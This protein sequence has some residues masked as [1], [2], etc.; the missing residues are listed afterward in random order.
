[1]KKYTHAWLALK[2]VEWLRN[3]AGRFNS[4]R[5]ERLERFLEFISKNPTTFVKGAWF[6]DTVIRDNIHGGH[7]WKY[8][9]DSSNGRV[10]KRRP[11]SHNNCLELVQN[12]L[13]RKISL[14]SRT[15]DLPDRCEA[16]GQ[17]IR[18]SILITNKNERGDVVLFNDS[19]V[20]LFFLMLSHYVS[21]AHVPVHCDKRDFYEPSRI[22]D[23]LE[24]HWEKEITKYFKIS[25][26]REE[27]D[28]DE[29]GNLQ[30]A[31]ERSGYDQ[32]I[33]HSCEEIL[34]QREW[35]NMSTVDNHWSALLGSTNNNFWDYLVSVC[36]V[37]FH[38]SMLMFPLN[39]PTGVDYETV[40]IMETV[41]FRERVDEYSP[42]ILAD[43]V[44][45]VSLLWL[46]AWERWELMKE[47]RR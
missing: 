29:G 42:Q 44:N 3:R 18:D 1:M 21:D 11:P 23:D 35:E 32:S 26:I 38:M 8:Y 6:P 43:A 34:R 46:A 37:S 28:L 24:T 13:N 31:A 16:L 14:V 36:L 27:F 39:P 19:Q 7:T 2:A 33:L 4:E 12:E 30:R 22:H 47:G 9:L 15:S 17:T 25:G 20:G 40:R 5:R 45:S 10:E 41:P